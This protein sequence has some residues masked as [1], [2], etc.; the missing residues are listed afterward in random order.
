MDIPKEAPAQEP[1]V[2][3]VIEPKIETEVAKE[4]EV[5]QPKEVEAP[6]SELLK[7]KQEKT[8]N[9]PLAVFLEEKKERKGLEKQIADL[10]KQINAGKPVDVSDEINALGEEY[11]VDAKFLAKLTNAIESKVKGS[12]EMPPEVAKLVQEHNEREIDRVFKEHYEKA[13]AKMP[14]YTEIADAGV[15]KTLSLLP[16]NAN[17]TFSQIIEQTYSRSISG[18]KT[19]ETTTPG[20]GKEPEPINY[21]KASKDQNYLAE[22]L[23]NPQLKAEYN[24]NLTKR[25]GNKL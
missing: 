19:I 22:I 8:D 9:V 15:I 23:S 14:E 6:V 21:A 10:Q 1:K 17:K 3:K 13:M 2:E 18:K 24:K 11:G 4:P 16:E 25:L 7:S 12:G 20:G 5:V